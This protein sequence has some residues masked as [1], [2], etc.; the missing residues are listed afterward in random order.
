[1]GIVFYILLLIGCALWGL[2]SGWRKG[3]FGQIGTLL[4][5]CFGIL[6]V[7]LLLPEFSPK[8]EGVVEFLFEK[9][10][11]QYLVESIGAFILFFVF[12]S[13]FSACGM[14]LNKVLKVITVKP[15]DNIL[16]CLFGLFKWLLCVSVC[17]NAILGLTQSGAL[18]KITDWGDG[19]PVELVMDISPSIFSTPSPA[20]LHHSLQL[21]Q[22]KTISLNEQANKESVMRVFLNVDEGV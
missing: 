15:F 8:I 5:V 1:M 11:P 19:N 17:Y 7:R 13:V 9:A 2:Y 16:G 20:D 22:A 12:F 3:L 6:G 10:D 18:L 14:I 4:G 21:Q